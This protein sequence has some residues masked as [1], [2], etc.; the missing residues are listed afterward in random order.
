MPQTP[1]TFKQGDRDPWSNKDFGCYLILTDEGTHHI[2]VPF[3]RGDDSK[4]WLSEG[5]QDSLAI[6]R[7]PKY[8]KLD[9]VLALI[10]SLTLVPSLEAERRKM[11]A[12]L[13]IMTHCVQ[14]VDDFLQ[15]IVLAKDPCADAIR[16]I[17]NKYNAKL[18]AL[19]NP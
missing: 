9:D 19:P 2:A 15:G 3:S 11:G 7:V 12:A 6:E 16:G 1:K 5:E 18:D 10:S 13:A 8:W 17:L 4:G 14:D